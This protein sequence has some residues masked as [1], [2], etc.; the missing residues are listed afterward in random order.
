MEAYY[1]SGKYSSRMRSPRLKNM[2][3][4][5]SQFALSTK[6]RGTGGKVLSQDLTPYTYTEPIG[7]TKLSTESH[8][9]ISQL[10]QKLKD[11]QEKYENDIENMQNYINLLRKKLDSSGNP[12]SFEDQL[13]KEK[14]KS[15]AFYKALKAKEKECQDLHNTSTISNFQNKI[16]LLTLDKNRLETN[17][18]EAEKDMKRLHEEIKC[19]SEIISNYKE[20][21]SQDQSLI[22]KKKFENLSKDHEQ[23]KKDISD[24]DHLKEILESK[25]K[26]QAG[27]IAFL[28]EKIKIYENLQSTQQKNDIRHN[29]KVNSFTIDEYSSIEKLLEVAKTECKIIIHAV[30]KEINDKFSLITLKAE[31]LENEENRI[32]HM[33]KLLQNR[34]SS[35]NFA[36]CNKLAKELEIAK[37]DLEEALRENYDLHETLEDLNTKSLE[38]RETLAQENIKLKE[39]IK[40]NFG[41]NINY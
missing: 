24:H 30:A 17:L 10:E 26:D 1:G 38:Q 18:N 5:L 37:Q 34:I 22:W 32:N 41:R 40:S 4:S 9:T 29:D 7:E 27:E 21:I 3:A 16:Q 8:Q 13:K 36:K 19:Q 11:T 6:A 28:N 12:S 31:Q 14:E 23:V 20:K 2:P 39:F 15:L 33:L 25:I 35:S